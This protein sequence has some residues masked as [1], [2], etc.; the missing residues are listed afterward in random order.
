MFVVNSELLV[1]EISKR[2]AM[3]SHRTISVV[4]LIFSRNNHNLKSYLK[5]SN[6][7]FVV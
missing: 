2:Y 5:K 1:Q 4:G 3:D 7:G 6:F